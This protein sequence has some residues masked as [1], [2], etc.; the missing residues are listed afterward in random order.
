MNSLD[1][2]PENGNFFEKNEFFS[3]LKNTAVLDEDY[4]NSKYLYQNL[5]MRNLSDMNDYVKLLKIISKLCKMN[6]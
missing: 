2:K 6:I 4:K 3:E 5:K 1:L